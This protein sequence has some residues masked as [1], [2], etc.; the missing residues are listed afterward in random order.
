[1]SDKKIDF[2]RA[3]RAMARLD[4][5]AKDHPELLG[6]SSQKEW[7]A[8][9]QEALEMQQVFNVIEAAELL[10]SHPETIRREIRRGILKAAKV[11]R[12]F[13]ISRKE[14]ADYWRAK[15]GGDLFNEREM[16]AEQRKE[17]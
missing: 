6:G 4:E 11:G 16:E 7:E 1:M 14:L 9:L 10:R 2:E 5:I 15:G 13:R 3:R 12:D 17:G 8:T